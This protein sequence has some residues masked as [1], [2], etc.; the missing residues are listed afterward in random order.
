MDEYSNTVSLNVKIIDFVPNVSFSVSKTSVVADETVEFTISVSDFDE[1][2]CIVFKSGD[3]STSLAFG[4]KNV[5]TKYYAES[6]FRYIENSSRYLYWC[7]KFTTFLACLFH[8][9]GLETKFND[10]CS[11]LN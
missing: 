11:Q 3:D 7:L 4:N 6:E 5:C 10:S 8:F 1:Y 2:T 9:S